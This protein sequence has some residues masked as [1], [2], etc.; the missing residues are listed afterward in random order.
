[1]EVS[2]EVVKFIKDNQESI[3]LSLRNSF[4]LDVIIGKSE[5][6]PSDL[7]N[8][9]LVLIQSGLDIVVVSVADDAVDNAEG[10]PNGFLEYNFID[11][12]DVSKAILLYLSRHAD[13][14]NA[15]QSETS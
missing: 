7:L 9:R 8:F 5:V 15:R 12:N 10:V 3:R 2:K 13:A 14:E 4:P 11:S 1:M 6:Y